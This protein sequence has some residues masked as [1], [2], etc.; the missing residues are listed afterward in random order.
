MDFKSD[1]FEA[2]LECPTKCYL[3]A[4]GEDRSGNEYADWAKAES[5]SY[6]MEGL[7]RLTEGIPPGDCVTEVHGPGDFKTAKWRFALDV[8]ARAQGYG[9]R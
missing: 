4:H 7:K 3:R 8:T 2:Y 9:I 1:T 5:E 6:R